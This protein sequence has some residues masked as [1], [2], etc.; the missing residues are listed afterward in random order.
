MG[1]VEDEKIILYTPIWVEGGEWNQTSGVWGNVGT[2]D[3]GEEGRASLRV[4]CTRAATASG[5]SESL[6]E[7]DAEPEIESSRPG[8]GE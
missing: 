5:S 7:E 2:E 1:G 6:S 8:V 3:S 4:L